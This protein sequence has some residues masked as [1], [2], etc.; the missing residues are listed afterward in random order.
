MKLSH[1]IT[2]IFQAPTIAEIVEAELIVES[3]I[4]AQC[5]AAIKANQFQL[6]LSCAKVEALRSW[7]THPTI[8]NSLQNERIR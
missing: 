8:I 4:I 2:N 7:K 3:K 6:H 5:E 1:Y